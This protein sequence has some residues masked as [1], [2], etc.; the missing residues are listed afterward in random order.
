MMKQLL[1]S[2]AR[3]RTPRQRLA[4]AASLVVHTAIIV[5][6]VQST[7]LP[8]EPPIQGRERIDTVRFQPPSPDP[9]PLRQRPSEARPTDQVTRAEMP[10]MP[11]VISTVIP[12][13]RF[14]APVTPDGSEFTRRSDGPLAPTAIPSAGTQIY[15][16]HYVDEPIIPLR[17]NTPP[18]Y[19]ATL[20]SLGLPGEVIA[21]F[22]VDTLGRTER[23]SIV[24]ITSA[25][26]L[27]AASVREA[28]L[29]AHFVPA[30]V[31]GRAV[32]QLA[33]QRFVF[34]LER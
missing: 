33:E 2:G 10:A 22:V 24:I 18:R 25:H 9:A 21:R 27:F 7:G 12:E 4:T 16:T 13:P 5:L 34:N 26:D 30:R 8:D 31:R 28:L 17:D 32:R 19:P 15:E 29:R 1:E 6:V 23:E 3:R 11:L 20:R 14:D